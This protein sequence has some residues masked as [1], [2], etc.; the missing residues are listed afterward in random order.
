MSAS[1]I[2]H[3][4]VPV[5]AREAKHVPELDGIRGIAIL[6]VLVGH[7]G[8]T[9]GGDTVKLGR[10]FGE[11]FGLGWIGVD[12]F[13]VL[14]GF[15]ITG[16]LLDSKGSTGYFSSFYARRTL[17]IFPLYFLY[18]FVFFHVALPLGGLL[19]HG[20]NI[21]RSGEIWYWLYLPNWWNG[22]GHSI[23]YLIH[24]WSLGIEEQFYFTWPLIVL[25]A[26]RKTLKAIC[27][28]LIVIS[29]L[30]RY[31]FTYNSPPPLFLYNFTPFR[32]EPIALGALVAI[33]VRE[34]ETSP[35][36]VR[37]MK[38]LWVPALLIFAG[39]SVGSGTTSLGA[40]SISRFGYTCIDLIFASFV[41]FVA[42]TVR[43]N[44]RVGMLT[45]PMLR[46]C[47]KYSYGMYVLHMPIV[48]FLAVPLAYVF[49]KTH[50]QLPFVR[51]IVA[52]AVGTGLTYI[53]A[54]ISWNLLESP[55][56]RLKRK[57]PLAGPA[58]QVIEGTQ[59]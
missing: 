4:P 50:L 21:D 44:H 26:S 19:H 54:L 12:L 45:H 39:M 27:L 46:S 1:L 42:L 49:S 33:L 22:S 56:L 18:V 28:M 3:Q 5:T 15:L 16:I 38:Y 13:F 32:M 52:I 7:F 23:K 17:R 25:I 47:G 36:V 43:G 11:V 51:V 20:E 59:R 37:L 55:F 53:A 34:T 35:F 57:F 14:S 9:A 29:P 2:S 8:S 41:F 6:I 48:I 31:I 58:P 40:V 24:F 30:L 10:A